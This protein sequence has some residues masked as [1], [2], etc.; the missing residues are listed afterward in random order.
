MT[1][2][3]PAPLPVE[4]DIALI[5]RIIPHRYP[6]LLVDK[7]RDI[8][9]FKS[10]IGIKNV[11]MNEQVFQGHFPGMPI[12]PGV[13]IIEAMAQTSGILVGLSVDLIDKNAKVF[14]M[15]VDGVKF[16][17]K[18]V[19]GD[20]MELHVVAVRGGGKVWKFEGRAMVNGELACEATFSAMFD[21]PKA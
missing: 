15:S 11:T 19:P 20:V 18:V 12:F 13:M 6:F 2:Q 8:V 14:F 10:C 4:A 7:V 1:D 17:R 9:P 5:Q 21:L 16:R 3:S